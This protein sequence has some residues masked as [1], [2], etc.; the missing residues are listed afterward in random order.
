MPFS[1][2]PEVLED[3]KAGKM[4]VLV[5]DEDRENEGDLVIAAEKITPAAINFMVT[6]A[7]GVVCLALTSDRCDRLALHP[8]TDLNTAQ[9]GTAFTVTVDA[10]KR[11]G[12]TTGVSASDRAKTIEVAIAEDAQPQDLSRPGH[13]NPLRAREGGVLV[14]AGQTEGSVD[15]ARLAGKRPAA[16]ICEIMNDDG[17]M[18]RLPDL[19]KFAAQ[20]ELKIISVEKLISY[21]LKREQFVKR[22]ETVMLPTNWGDF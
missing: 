20:H 5:D 4:V 1:P 12:V 16:V 17:T 19:R 3:L 9:M 11:F 22:I 2:I 14:R 13:I 8:Q 15:L 21:R 7:R 18:A 10:H 6:H